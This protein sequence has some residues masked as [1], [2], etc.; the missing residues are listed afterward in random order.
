[1]SL[2]AEQAAIVP[3]LF[4]IHS[5]S[6]SPEQTLSNRFQ[7][8][9]SMVL[10]TMQPQSGAYRQ[11]SHPFASRGKAGDNS[12]LTEG[13]GLALS[14]LERIATVSGRSQ[15]RT[16]CRLSSAVELYRVFPIPELF[17]DAH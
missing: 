1:V 4:G 7:L 2:Y 6:S 5:W 10:R 3:A 8:P 11:G 15:N 17:L 13:S 12:V 9:S 14:G 16:A